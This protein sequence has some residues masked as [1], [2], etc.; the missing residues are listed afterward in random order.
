MSLLKRILIVATASVVALLGLTTPAHASLSQCHDDPYS[1]LGNICF[2]KDVNY[3]GS[4]IEWVE[5]PL[6]TC[7]NVPSSWNDVASSG[8]N[9]MWTKDI[10]LYIDANCSRQFARYGPQETRAFFSNGNDVMTS[11]KF[12]G[13][14][15]APMSSTYT[16]RT[17]AMP[18][19]PGAYQT[20]A[21]NWVIG[22]SLTCSSITNACS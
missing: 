3:Q 1:H 9:Y 4:F 11:F 12:L 18:G 20:A 19:D 13:T 2:W 15:N 8:A 5:E 22:P 14:S 16:V 17:L 10:A 21:G 6:N 7:W